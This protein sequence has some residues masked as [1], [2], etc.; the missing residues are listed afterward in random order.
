MNKLDLTKPV[1]TR[2]G[3]PVRILCTNRQ[4]HAMGAVVGL[5]TD[6]KGEETV[7]SWDHDGT[8]SFRDGTSSALINVPAT[9]RVRVMLYKTPAGELWA[10]DMPM[11]SDTRTWELVAV[12]EVEFTEGEGL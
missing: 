4:H 6:G 11:Q 3:R 12:K 1:Q 7:A 10:R 8:S 9:R 5:I 2:D